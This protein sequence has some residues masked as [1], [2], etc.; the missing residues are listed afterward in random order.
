MKILL[1]GSTGFIGKIVRTNL[2]SPQIELYE[3]TS[4]ELDLRDT[5]SIEH[6]LKIATFNG[7]KNLISLSIVLWIKTKNILKI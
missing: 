7:Q 6:Y 5:L 3:P 1:I 4:I 2:F